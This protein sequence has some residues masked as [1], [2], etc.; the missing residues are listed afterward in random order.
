MTKLEFAREWT[1]D[2]EYVVCHTS[3]S[4]GA[5]K[6]IRLSKEFMR[7]SARRTNDFFCINDRSHLHTC[8]DFCYIASKMMLVRAEEAQCRL[9]SE[10]PS[11]RPLSEIDKEERIDLLSVVP[12][13][14]EWILDS[15]SPWIGIRNILV[16]GSALP[17][18]IRRK[19][20]LSQ[21]VVWET[22]GMT[23]TASHIAL[24]RVC[25]DESIPFETLPG[26]KV[27]VNERGCLVV[28]LPGGD[29]LETND[30]AEVL[31]S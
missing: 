4:T 8:L 12:S 3:G 7:E 10:K 2:S 18:T 15:A 11:N 17:Q 5:P 24:R 31:S 25:E 28:K 1:D 26:I 19:I 27:N 16:G 23:E 13:Q 9:T 14:M 20:A 30:L 29:S 6:E 22:Y 21:Y